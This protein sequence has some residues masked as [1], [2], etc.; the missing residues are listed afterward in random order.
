MKT[1]MDIETEESED[2]AQELP[3]AEI[4]AIARMAKEFNRI[5]GKDALAL[6]R[7]IQWQADQHELVKVR[8]DAYLDKTHG[9]PADAPQAIGHRSI[10]SS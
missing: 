1:E 5:N 3:A 9:S 4:A 6:L 2:E 7:H 10:V 8:L